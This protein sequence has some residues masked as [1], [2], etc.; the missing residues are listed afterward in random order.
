M[1]PTISTI[2]LALTLSSFGM[3]Q[4]QTAPADPTHGTPQ[5]SHDAMATSS[6]SAKPATHKKKKKRSAVKPAAASADETG[7]HGT[8]QTSGPK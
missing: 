3:A 2:V 7:T 8:P 4:Q 6:A 1:R 5:T